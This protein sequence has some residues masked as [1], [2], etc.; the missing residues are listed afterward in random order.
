[1]MLLLQPRP[2]RKDTQRSSLVAS[3]IVFWKNC[4]EEHLC[5]NTFKN[6]S[7]IRWCSKLNTGD[8]LEDS[9]LEHNFEII[10]TAKKNN[11][12]AFHASE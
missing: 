7:S 11:A 4:F 3:G 12:F 8:L 5:W 2:Q 10:S 6:P 9:D 1:M